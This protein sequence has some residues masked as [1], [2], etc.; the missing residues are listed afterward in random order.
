MGEK[1]EKYERELPDIP[2]GETGD[3]NVTEIEKPWDRFYTDS[4]ATVR[5]SQ[6][7]PVIQWA[8][9]SVLSNLH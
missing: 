1:T 2:H 3:W 4:L 9:G 8:V 7:P 6:D 5:S